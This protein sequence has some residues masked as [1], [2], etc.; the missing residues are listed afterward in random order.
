LSIGIGC[1]SYFL[2]RESLVGRSSLKS[3]Y[4]CDHYFSGFAIGREAGKAGDWRTRQ[5]S[6]L[7]FSAIS[8]N[9]MASRFPNRLRLGST[10]WTKHAVAHASDSAQ[11]GAIT[12]HAAMPSIGRPVR[13]FRM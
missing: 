5:S 7:P 11:V 4:L 3:I 1:K 2:A 6:R 13:G 12:V 10:P 9:R 8:V